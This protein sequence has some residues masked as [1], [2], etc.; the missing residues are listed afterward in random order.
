MVLEVDY[1]HCEIWKEWKCKFTFFLKSSEKQQENLMNSTK[2]KICRRKVQNVL[3]G[4]RRKNINSPVHCIKTWDST[5][6]QHDLILDFL[7]FSLPYFVPCINLSRWK[8]KNKNKRSDKVG[9]CLVDF[10]KR[11]YL[12]L[13]KTSS[14]IHTCSSLSILML[15]IYSIN[16]LVSK[17]SAPAVSNKANEAFIKSLT[18][19]ISVFSGKIL[20]R[21]NSALTSSSPP[22]LWTQKAT[23]NKRITPKIQSK[24][25]IS[26]RKY[27]YFQKQF[28]FIHT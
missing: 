21:R 19:C 25:T 20:S 11:L 26:E 7:F 27:W 16:S 10:R 14:C 6:G 17:P 4:S 13:N 18:Y 22:Y 9:S 5:R 8:S 23:F 15:R 1:H 2:I 24:M 28:G 3:C 12:E